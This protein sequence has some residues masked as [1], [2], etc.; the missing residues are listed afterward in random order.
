MSKWEVT[1]NSCWFPLTED[2]FGGG[3]IKENSDKKSYPETMTCIDDNAN[4]H[5]GVSDG[6]ASKQKTLTA[7][8]SPGLVRMLPGD[9][10]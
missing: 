9:D 10:E 7:K 4:S 3:R 1:V 6:A 5:L 8:A 2:G